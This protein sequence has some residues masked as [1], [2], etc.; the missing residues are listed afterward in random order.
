MPTSIFDQEIA[1]LLKN[2]GA[3]YFP[4][5]EDWRDHWIYFLLVDR[6]N[7]PKAGPTPPDYPCNVYQGGSFRGI[8]DQL[9]YLKNL[10]VGAIWISPV[11]Y[12]PQW[13]KDY[14]GGYGIQDFLQLEPR[15]CSNPEA[16]AADPAIADREFRQLVDQ[17]HKHGIYV[18]LDIVLNHAGNLFSYFT[19]DD[20]AGWNP[21]GE[22]PVHWRDGHGVPQPDWPDIAAIPDLPRNAG[23]WPKEF[24]R[25]D[26]F[27]RRGDLSGSGDITLG[28]FGALKEFVTEYMIPDS[29]VYPVRNIL[30]RV[31][32]YLIARF[33]LDG[34]RI[35]TLQYIEPEFARI[36]GNA[37]REFALSIG[38]KNF[39]TFGEV[40]KDDDENRIAEFIGRD[41]GTNEEFI[42]VD[43]A[44][45]FPVRIRLFNIFKGFMPPSELANHYNDRREILKRTIS[46]HGDA[47]SFYVTFMDNHDIDRRFHNKQ[48]PGQ[49][50]SML[51]CLMTL[52]GIPCIYEGMEQGFD[53]YAPDNDRRREYV[54]ETLWGKPDSFSTRNEFYLLIQQLS[55]LRNQ[56]PA[57][58][59]GRQYFRECSGNGIDFEYSSYNGGI[60]SFSRILNDREVIVCAN[61]NVNQPSTVYILVDENLS[62]P[63]KMWQLLFSSQ[64]TAGLPVPT[65]I[66]N[67][68]HSVQVTL[69]PMEAKILA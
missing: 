69:Q 39:F 68:I 10:G 57:L 45:D 25:N 28:D 29:T 17:A 23:I 59:Y 34:F 4:S 30:I 38:K 52:Q 42:G 60:V 35:D 56:H 40:W 1:D 62:P 9:T 50:K 48:Y 24:H 8:M 61:T 27:R 15:Y 53:G 46:S 3:T 43:A 33:D 22:Y 21:D 58:R 26:Y 12:N 63:D 32:Q 65:T 55:A 20:S 14:W 51:T 66:R 6:F 41:T 7:N 16:A 44:I 64:Q 36:F 11:L 31:F 2:P 54:R 37:M 19:A 18:I 5:P 47:G 49:T 13:F 67:R